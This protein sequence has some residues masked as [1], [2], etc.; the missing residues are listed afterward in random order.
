[1]QYMQF[2]KKLGAG[3]YKMVFLGYDSETGRE[4]AWNVIS[5]LHLDS[6][7]RKRISDEINIAKSLS[8]KRII[9]FINAWQNKG[10]K[11]VVFITER[12]TGGSLR[13]Y[14]NRLNAP[15]K[16]KVAKDWCRQ[17]LEG[18]AYLHSGMKPAPIIHRDLKVIF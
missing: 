5:T 6:G 3:A 7:A 1:M 14:I 10:S 9:K 15:L 13:Q 8:H 2:N 4:V 12:V 18:L 11:E 16:V 17:I